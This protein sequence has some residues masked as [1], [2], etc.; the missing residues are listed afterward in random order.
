MLTSGILL[1]L[2]LVQCS[3]QKVDNGTSEEDSGITVPAENYGGYSSQVEWGNH[4]VTIAGCNDCHTPKKMTEKGPVIDS[5]LLLSGHPVN[6]PKIEVNKAE[7]E[8]KHL[9]VTMDLT[10]WVGP[11]GTS[12]AANLTPHETGLGNWS[13]EQFFKA[14]REGKFKGLDGS[15]TLLP[16]MPWEMFKHFSDDEIKAIFAYLKSVKP[17]D[18]IVPAA[19]PPVSAPQ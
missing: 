11:W 8:A 18:N 19:L 16:P 17:V 4:L 15:R 13:E 5:S 12:Y 3:D 7:M 14:L 10:E 9:V 1:S 6:M 2:G